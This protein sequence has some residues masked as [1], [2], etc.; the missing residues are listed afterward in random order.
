VGPRIQVPGGHTK[1]HEGHPARLPCQETWLAQ[2]ST[3]HTI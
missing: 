1:P 3:T 2:G